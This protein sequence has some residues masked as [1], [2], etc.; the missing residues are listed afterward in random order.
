MKKMLKRVMILMAALLM[1]SGCAEMVKPVETDAIQVTV[2]IPPQAWVVRQIAGDLVNVQ[3]M[4]GPG[5]DPHTYEPTPAQMVALTKTDIYFTIGIEFEDAWMPKLA[6]SN[7]VMKL[8][9]SD[10]GV[11]RIS[12]GP[13]QDPEASASASNVQEG[14]DPHIWYSPERMKLISQN[15][16]NELSDF[17][18]QNKATYQAN[19][20]QLISEIDQLQT[21]VGEKL[22]GLPRDHFLIIHPTLG[23]LAE[24]YGLVQIAIES[25]GQE[26]G[27]EAMAALITEARQYQVSAVFYQKGNNI[28]VAESIA[29]QIGTSQLF[30][31]DSM[32]EDWPAGLMQAVDALREALK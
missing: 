10:F 6:N 25:E 9:A 17:N 14:Q 15:I 1:L 26:P 31:I 30:E 13:V 21:E 11:Q 8:V 23:Y 3:T 16:A 27:P 20:A 18:P 24:D 5:D 28:R 29:R 12:S 22:S 32:P 2:S 19:L 4:V 7:R